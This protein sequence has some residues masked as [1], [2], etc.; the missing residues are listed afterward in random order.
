M[1]LATGRLQPVGRHLDPDQP[2]GAG[3][4]RLV[5][6]IVELLAAHAARA[7]H[8]QRLDRAAA[9]HDLGEGLELAAREERARRPVSSRPKRRSGLSE[10]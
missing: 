2:L 8:A 5:G 6:E 1:N 9:G 10:P 7:G 4:L 3:L